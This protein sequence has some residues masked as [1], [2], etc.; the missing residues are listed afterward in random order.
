[1]V[2]LW[3]YHHGD[4]ADSIQMNTCHFLKGHVKHSQHYEEMFSE[5]VHD[6][7]DAMHIPA[8]GY[9]ILTYLG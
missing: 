1:M 6:D 5:W 2:N 7:D 3:W 4:A 9:S 8:N